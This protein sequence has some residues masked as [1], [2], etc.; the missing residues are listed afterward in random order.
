MSF[1]SRRKY[2]KLLAKINHKSIIPRFMSFLVGCFLIACAYNIFLVEND[3]V[4]GGVGGI[5]IILNSIFSIENWKIILIANIFLLT[6]SY[7]TLEKGKTRASVIGSL[8]LPVFVYLTANINVW[9]EIDPTQ[10][11]LAA[12][13]GGL[14][15]G[16]GAGMV[17]KAGFT[18]GGTDIINQIISKYAKIS[19]GKSMLISDGLIVLSSALFFG[20]MNL[21]YSIIVL[22]IIS[23]MSDKV[24]LGISDNKAFYIIT[25]HE[26]EVKEY[27]FTNLGHSVT[28]FNAKGGFKKEKENVLLCVLPT[29]DYYKLKAGIHEID[30][31][32]FFVVT[33]AYEVFGGE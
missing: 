1:I 18:T 24:I 21:L 6:L 13:F 31:D 9:L 23:L 2:R 4:P 12:A 8:L 22:Y 20:P 26:E 14:I 33:D 5:A 28:I 30:E 3:I 10:K 11:V 32:A 16:F 15:Y 19:V 7:F 27:I 17:F 29:S 25:D